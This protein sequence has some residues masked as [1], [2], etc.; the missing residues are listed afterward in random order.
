MNDK[1]HGETRLRV[2]TF[3]PNRKCTCDSLFFKRDE[4]G[5]LWC[6]LCGK[7]VVSPDEPVKVWVPEIV[8][9]ANTL[10]THCPKGHP[11]DEANTYI[12]KSGGRECRECKACRRDGAKRRREELVI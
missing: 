4:D 9:N 3:E 10:K 5:V 1:T 2:N 7:R 11:Y 8:I 6:W 12:N